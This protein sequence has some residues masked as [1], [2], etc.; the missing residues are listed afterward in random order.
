[1]ILFIKGILCLIILLSLL[2]CIKKF[3]FIWNHFPICTQLIPAWNFFAPF[4][5]TFD[6]HLL[7][8]EISNHEVGEWQDLYTLKDKRSMYC[9]LWNP[10][11]K[12]IK[13]FLDI[14]LDLISFSNKVHDNKQVYTSLPYLQL[15]NYVSSLNHKASSDKI[16]FLILT[17]SR[18]QDYQ[19][20]FLSDV[21][22]LSR[23]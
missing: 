3:D 2:R 20:A 21:H 18:A 17:N 10:E 22:P 13:S 4:P 16:Q 12:S 5:N 7:Y 14:A 19:V 1:M 8:R 9:F 15:L 11:K 6:Y 23:R